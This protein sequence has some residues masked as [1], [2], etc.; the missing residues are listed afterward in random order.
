MTT[1]QTTTIAPPEYERW[2]TAAEAAAYLSLTRG[3]LYDM[4]TEGRGPVAYRMGGA[5]L[6]YRRSDLDAWVFQEAQ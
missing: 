4:R 2:L 6:R 5:R 1:S 3:A